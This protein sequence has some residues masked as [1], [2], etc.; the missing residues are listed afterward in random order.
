[1]RGLTPWK[2]D[3]TTRMARLP[4][5]ILAS[6]GLALGTAATASADEAG[7][8]EAI[9]SLD[10]YAIEC[11]GCAQ[12]AVNVGYRACAAFNRGGDQ[13]AVQAVLDSYNADTAGSRN[14]YA[15]LFA[16]YAAYQLCPEHDGEIG[17]I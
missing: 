15:T 12:D 8:I 1:M 13:A 5:A 2:M 3:V 16:Q 6:L 4:I 7:F 17:P 10:H 14:Y 9:D 11:A